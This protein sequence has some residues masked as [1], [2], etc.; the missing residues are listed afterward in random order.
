MSDTIKDLRAFSIKVF[1]IVEDF[2]CDYEIDDNTGI[3]VGGDDIEIADMSEVQD[4]ENFYLIRQ[5]IRAGD[6]GEWELA[7]EAINEIA[8]RYFFVQCNSDS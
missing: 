6:D 8:S 5:L 7:G 1:D 4:K 2:L 3:Y